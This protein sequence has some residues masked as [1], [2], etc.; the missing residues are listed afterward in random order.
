MDAATD[1]DAGGAG[2]GD[3]STGRE[4]VPQG[5]PAPVSRRR[6][7]GWLVIGLIVIGGILCGWGAATALFYVGRW[8]GVD[9][10]NRWWQ[11][12]YVTTAYIVVAVFVLVAGYYWFR[13]RPS[14]TDP[15]A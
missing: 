3:R 6:R 7:W 4:L 14:D 9:F 2:I 5:L 8:F 11:I 15:G 13:R 12:P 10:W 1:Q